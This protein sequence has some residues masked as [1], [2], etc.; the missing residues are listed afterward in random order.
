[1][2]FYNIDYL[3]LI[4]KLFLNQIIF[5]FAAEFDPVGLNIPVGWRQPSYKVKR[6][7]EYSKASFHIQ[8]PF[9]LRDPVGIQKLKYCELFLKYYVL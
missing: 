9:F 1:M 8:F 4:S 3:I 5:I 7:T 2:P 6:K